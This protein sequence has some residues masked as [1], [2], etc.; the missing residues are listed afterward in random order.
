M[1]FGAELDDCAAKGRITSVMLVRTGNTWQTYI[2]LGRT[3]GYTSQCAETP[4]ESLGKALSLLPS[5]ERWDLDNGFAV[6]PPAQ[7][8][9][10]PPAKKAADVD[11]LLG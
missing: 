7:T 3:S 1:N 2:K 9:P 10:S 5:C 11:D 6:V 8:Q 4:S